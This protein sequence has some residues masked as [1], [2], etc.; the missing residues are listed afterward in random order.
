MCNNVSCLQIIDY[1]VILHP[2]SY[3]REAWNVMDM[4]VVSCAVASFTM[5]MM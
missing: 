2:G 3:L 4:T 1:G 5:D